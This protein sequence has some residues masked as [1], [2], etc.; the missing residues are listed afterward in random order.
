MS[1]HPHDKQFWFHVSFSIS[2]T[3]S[4]ALGRGNADYFLQLS[5]VAPEILLLVLFGLMDI[6]VLVKVWLLALKTDI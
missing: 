2:G 1:K 6:H 5:P 3:Q 4:P